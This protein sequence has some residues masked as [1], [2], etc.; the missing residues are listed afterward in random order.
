[1][2]EI[3]AKPNTIKEKKEQKEKNIRTIKPKAN[4]ESNKE[5]DAEARVLATRL[6]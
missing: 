2:I 5:A 3:I 4:V 6:N 1:M